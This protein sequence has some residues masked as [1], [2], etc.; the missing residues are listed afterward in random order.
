MLGR[1]ALN[2]LRDDV[3]RLIGGGLSRLV[4]ESLHKV[5]GVVASIVLHVA[6]Q[7]V[8]GLVRR[9][10]GNAGEL[11]RVVGDQFLVPGHL[12]G[13]LGF[14]FSERGIPALEPTLISL[15][16]RLALAK[17]A[18]LLVGLLFE[19]CELC[20]SR[21]HLLFGLTIDLVRFLFCGEHDFLA[22][23]VRLTLGFLEDALGL[24]LGATDGLRG[25]ALARGDPDKEDDHPRDEGGDEAGRAA[26]DLAH[27]RDLTLMRRCLQSREG[28]T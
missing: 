9:H 13:D 28:R 21:A 8:F 24:F 11:A 12:V 27:E 16:R 10:P 1:A 25:E 7:D 3:F 23:G 20:V 5:G 14:L 17:R 19:R 4:L 18:L 22:L 2:G 15:D 26:E 6:E